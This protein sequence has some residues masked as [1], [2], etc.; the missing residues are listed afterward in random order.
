M[1]DTA[2]TG[3]RST[4]TDVVSNASST[5]PPESDASPRDGSDVEIQE[6]QEECSEDDVHRLDDHDKAGSSLSEELSAG[7]TP[8]EQRGE[9]PND[10][11]TASPQDQRIASSQEQRLESQQGQRGAS[12]QGQRFGSP[13]DQRFA[14]PH[15]QRGASLHDQRGASLHD[16]RGAPLPDQRGASL[17][18][19]RGASLPG[20]KGAS[21]PG[22]RLA[23]PQDQRGASPQDQRG[24]STQDKGLASTQDQRGASPQDHILASPQ[25]HILASPQDHIGASP[26]DHILASPQDQRL[27]SPQDQ[28]ADSGD[29]SP[30]VST[31]DRPTTQESLTDA[32]R[33][34]QSE[35]GGMIHDVVSAKHSP[36][37]R[38]I[39]SRQ[40]QFEDAFSENIKAK[41]VDHGSADEASLSTTNSQGYSNTGS[42]GGCCCQQPREQAKDETD[43]ND[44]RHTGATATPTSLE[45]AESH[46]SLALVNDSRVSN[47]SEPNL[48]VGD[49][50]RSSQY[51]KENPEA[52]EN[53]VLG[54][55]CQQEI[56]EEAF[57][58]Q[59]AGEENH[60]K[61]EI[62]S[63]Q[64]RLNTLIKDNN[65][66]GMRIVALESN[67]LEMTAKL[68]SAEKKCVPLEVSPSRRETN[69]SR[70]C[71]IL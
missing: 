41:D 51:K 26:Q 45:T 62:T 4:S 61:A 24:A 35:Q 9:I 68:L 1:E 34:K 13:Q 17:P 16:Q 63:L 11:N 7:A 46:A 43:T 50:L 21:L 23:S 54:Q 18:D 27:A 57:R 65:E 25:D 10:E 53:E 59:S 29:K 52:E 20:Q 8:Q 70:T 49:S 47:Q 38:L 40:S 55:C 71:A 56:A 12:L 19:Q 37:E 22:Q 33:D 58:A 69:K 3:G 32:D 44:N 39:T 2:S 48:E 66:K 36:V 64:I 30:D 28:I 5:I 67:L 42:L 6:Q 14:S 31:E 60:L 15:D